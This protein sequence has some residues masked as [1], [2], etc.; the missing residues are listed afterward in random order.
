MGRWSAAP[1]ST[2]C[3]PNGLRRTL[4]R[5]VKHQLDWIPAAAPP[6]LTR[7]ECLHLKHRPMTILIMALI[8]VWLFDPI[9]LSFPMPVCLALDFD[10]NPA[11]NSGPGHDLSRFRF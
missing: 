2:A 3:P 9:S 8:V 11:L 5:F 1:V 6:A 10:R 4:M 7:N